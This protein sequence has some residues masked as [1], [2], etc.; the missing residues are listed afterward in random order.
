MTRTGTMVAL[1]A[2][3]ALLSAA[4]HAQGMAVIASPGSLKWQAGPPDL[5]KGTL[6]A[7]LFG[8][9]SKPEPYALRLKF[10]AGA[11]IAPHTHPVDEAVT[12][13]AGSG[14]IGLGNA[15]DSKTA[16]PI[17]PG[18]FVFLPKGTPH[19]ASFARATVVQLN[20]TG[21]L[22]TNYLKTAANSPATH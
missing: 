8:D 14:S 1:A 5:P 10:P 11:K 17:G 4:A 15:A 22:A 7:V 20:G 12:V 2:V 9:P 18:A 6:M 13:I 21:P 19:Y 3:F 16:I